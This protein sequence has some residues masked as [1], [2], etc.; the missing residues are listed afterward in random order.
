MFGEFGRGDVG[1]DDRHAKHV[2]QLTKTTPN[3]QLT[4][5]NQNA[6][7][8]KKVVHR[9]SFTQKFRVRRHVHITA[10]DDCLQSFGCTHRH[11][12]A[13]NDDGARPHERADFG[14]D[15]FDVRE[16]C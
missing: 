14:N 15:L 2:V 13:G 6:I 5:T 8:M 10:T 9:T 7:G 1:H 3:D 16:V 11:G 12:R 4:G